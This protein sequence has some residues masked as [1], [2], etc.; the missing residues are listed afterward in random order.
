M[1]AYE[2]YDYKECN[3]TNASN[4]AIEMVYE[5]DDSDLDDLDS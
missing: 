4:S 5:N 3:T 1:K 2:K